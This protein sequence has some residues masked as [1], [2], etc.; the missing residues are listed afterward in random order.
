MFDREE[1][2]EDMLPK[3]PRYRCQSEK[4]GTAL[5]R[6]EEWGVRVFPKADLRQG[7]AERRERSIVVEARQGGEIV[8][9]RGAVCFRGEERGGRVLPRGEQT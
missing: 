3:V 2:R 9:P 1:R 7:V 6:G 4:E 5:P 8:F